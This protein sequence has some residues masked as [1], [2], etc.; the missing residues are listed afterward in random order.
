MD[1]SMS[2]APLVSESS[3]SFGAPKEVAGSV[4]VQLILPTDAKKQRK[5]TKQMFLDRGMI[6]DVLLR[7]TS[8]IMNYGSFRVWT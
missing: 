7:F 3:H 8:D 4:D 5:Q 1:A 2:G 6:P